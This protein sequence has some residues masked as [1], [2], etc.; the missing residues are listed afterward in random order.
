MG[1]IIVTIGGYDISQVGH[2]VVYIMGFTCRYYS[3]R[4]EAITL[5]ENGKDF[6]VMLAERDHTTVEKVK[7]KI[8][9]RI[10]E[11][12]HDPDPERR[13]QWERIPC[14]GDVPT[15]EEWLRYSVKRLKED[16]REDLLR[17]Y[18]CD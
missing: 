7:E 6:F 8:S 1:V 17:H 15:P 12:L 3:Y 9:K 10:W 14:A 4:Q 16:G 5:Q 13:A 11:G 2:R 18:L